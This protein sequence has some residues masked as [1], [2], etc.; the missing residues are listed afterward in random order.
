VAE[1]RN[2][3]IGVFRGFDAAIEQKRCGRLLERRVHPVIQDIFYVYASGGLE[4]LR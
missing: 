3:E 4:D 1:R 2:R